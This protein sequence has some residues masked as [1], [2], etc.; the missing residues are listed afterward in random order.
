MPPDVSPEKITIFVGAPG[1]AKTTTLLVEVGKVMESGSSSRK[2]GFF[3]FSKK[4]AEEGR[5][6]ASAKFDLPSEEFPHFRTIHSFAFKYF[7]LSRSQVLGWTHIKELGVKL[8]LEFKGR[9]EVLDGDVYGMNDADRMLFLEG[10]ARNTKR[11]LRKV[12]EDASEDSID[13]FELD[14][15][16]KAL[17]A[18]KKSRGLW[19]FNDMLE[20][21]SGAD[22]R[23][24]P[25]F[26][27]LAIDEFQDTSLLQWD[28]IRLLATNARQVIVAG[29]DCQSIHGWSGSSTETFVNLQGRQVTLTQSYRIPSTVHKLAEAISDRISNKRPRSWIP[30][31]QAG[32]VNW[33]RTVDEADLSQGTWLLLA[34][35]GYMLD[36]LE[37]FCL[38]QGF[39][40]NSVNRDPLKSRSLVAIR[41]WENLRKG[42]DESS[43]AVLE[44]LRYVAARDIPME[45]L[46]Q[47]K[48]DDPGRMR[49]MPELVAAGLKTTAIWHESLAKVSPSERDYF[50]AARRRGE[51]LLGK[52]RIQISTIH[53]SKGGEA[54]N[55]LLVT[56]MSLRTHRNMEQK[57]DDECRVF[58]VGCTRCKETLN[59]VMPRTDLHFDL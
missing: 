12:W 54:E 9:G 51:K 4:A 37:N 50:I 53:A 45:L 1:T 39:S 59:I 31:P 22:P 33:L 10:L 17:A 18:F 48:A 19:D 49:G 7:G 30:R 8:G 13:W 44:C 23:T 29:D 32:A 20:N 24:L 35:N 36:E 41:T 47:L 43:E 3:A 25:Q 57:P 27:L 40:F 55:V 6:R 26:D 11:P 2:I 42:R 46:K 15:F 14:R 28:V 34:R 5:G 38:S 56:D 21:L 58:Y 52:P 16:A